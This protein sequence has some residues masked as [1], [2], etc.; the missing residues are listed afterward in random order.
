MD[1]TIITSVTVTESLG[2][3]CNAITLF[4]ILSSFDVKTHVFTLI[5]I[6]KYC[7][8]GISFSYILGHRRPLAANRHI[9]QQTLLMLRQKP[10]QKIYYKETTFRHLKK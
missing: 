6:G 2:L 5:L 8:K 7:Y 1:P 4:Y 10:S 9:W 3:A